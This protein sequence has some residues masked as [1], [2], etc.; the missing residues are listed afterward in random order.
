MTLWEP[1]LYLPVKRLC[2]VIGIHNG[3]LLETLETKT[4]PFEVEIRNNTVFIVMPPD[5]GLAELLRPLF[6]TGQAFLGSL[7]SLSEK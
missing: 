1:T 3:L 7:M 4:G 6:Q 5:L 2:W